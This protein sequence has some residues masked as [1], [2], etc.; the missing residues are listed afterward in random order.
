MKKS[1]LFLTLS[2]SL[3]LSACAVNTASPQE[4]AP[5]TVEEPAVAAEEPTDEPVSMEIN[6]TDALDREVTFPETPSRIVYGG[7]SSLMI[8]DAL[9]LFP[10]IS[11]RI[12][13][14]GDTNQ[15]FGNFIQAIDPNFDQ[16]TLLS[17]QASIEE[18][19][20]NNPDAVLLK[21]FLAGDYQ[22]PM[23]ELGINTVFLNL[24]TPEQF[25]TDILTLGEMLGEQARAEEI[26][27]TY[28]SNVANIS[29]TVAG[30]SE[31]EKPSVLVIYYRESDGAY[32]YNVPPLSWMQ[33]TNVITA[34]GTPV[35]LENTAKSWNVVGFEQIA[36]WNPDMVF[37]IAYRENA[38]A[39]VDS[40]LTDAQW[41]SL[42]AVRNEQLY[43]FPGD[44]YSWDQ[45]DPRWILG[46]KWLAWRIHP[47]L[48]PSFDTI[49]EVRSFYRDMYMLDDATIDAVIMPLLRGDYA[50]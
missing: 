8:A 17:G 14:A 4:A 10:N 49:S 38:S 28:N 27:E 16:K 1:L 26:V 42:S 47:D 29:D 35:W 24:E 46:L 34:G 39:L 33:T 45:P 31:E 50:D 22:Q 30:L 32:T 11:E 13:A 9:Y 44:F 18:M 3:I 43:A 6:I 12:V 21:N 23:E 25:N 40:L 37:L 36:A 5:V 7:K 15:N 41:Q 20:A 19:L 2:F 48:F